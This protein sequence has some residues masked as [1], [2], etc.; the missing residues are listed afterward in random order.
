MS[1][2]CWPASSAT[3]GL[4]KN[5]KEYYFPLAVPKCSPREIM[6]EEEEKAKFFL[7]GAQ[8]P[9][10]QL[11]YQVACFTNNTTAAGTE[12]SLR[13]KHLFLRPAARSPRS[14]SRPKA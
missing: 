13:L 12:L 10:A 6:S 14:T 4:W 3:A 5:L 1:W 2:R 9:Q 7:D 11:A 8:L